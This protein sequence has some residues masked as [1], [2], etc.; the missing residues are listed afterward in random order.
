M[1]MVVNLWNRVCFPIPLSRSLHNSTARL[2]SVCLPIMF[3]RSPQATRRSQIFG[4]APSFEQLVLNQDLIRGLNARKPSNFSDAW[5]LKTFTIHSIGRLKTCWCCWEPTVDLHQKLENLKEL[6][7]LFLPLTS[8]VLLNF[9][10]HPPWTCH[11][12]K[13]WHFQNKTFVSI[14]QKI[15]KTAI[16]PNGFIQMR[17]SKNYARTIPCCV[18]LFCSSSASEIT[19]SPLMLLWCRGRRMMW[20]SESA[21]VA[22]W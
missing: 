20:L 6:V 4:L 15:P 1:F 10:V 12:Q 18:I 9:N 21:T 3:A 5:G 2:S 13:C 22:S 16:P 17:S 7:S 14:N 19:S 8:L 11:L